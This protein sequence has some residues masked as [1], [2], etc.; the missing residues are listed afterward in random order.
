MIL[1]H[2]NLRFSHASQLQIKAMFKNH[3]NSKENLS[4][5]SVTRNFGNGE[6]KVVMVQ[7]VTLVG[8]LAL[9]LAQ[10]HYSI[11][12]LPNGDVHITNPKNSYA[13]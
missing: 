11:Q 8:P 12:P 1:Y 6:P 7:Y 3:Q 5:V 9:L 4:A 13:N 2:Y 10:T